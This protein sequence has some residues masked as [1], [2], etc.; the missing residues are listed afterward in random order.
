MSGLLEN[1]L[2]W[3][4]SYHYSGCTCLHMNSEILFQIFKFSKALFVCLSSYYLMRHCLPLLEYCGISTAMMNLL[5]GTCP[6]HQ[7][8]ISEYCLLDHEDAL[9]CMPHLFPPH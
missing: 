1:V 5:M 3:C 8:S 2:N 4:S 9:T 6:Y 7:Y